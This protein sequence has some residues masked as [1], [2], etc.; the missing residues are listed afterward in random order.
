MCQEERC[1]AFGVTEVSTS[2][3]IK[4]ATKSDDVG[5]SV[6]GRDLKR[7]V[8]RTGARCG[9]PRQSELPRGDVDEDHQ[10]G[11]STIDEHRRR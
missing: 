8:G 10:R 4:S 11:P 2:P 9:T 1:G 6:F 5:V 7:L 3:P